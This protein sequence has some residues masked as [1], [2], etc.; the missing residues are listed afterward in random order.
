MNIRRKEFISEIKRR[1][2]AE[3]NRRLRELEEF[4]N[5]PLHNRVKRNDYS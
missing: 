5:P 1:K 4:A 2:L 3:T